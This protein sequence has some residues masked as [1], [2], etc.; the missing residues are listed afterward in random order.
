MF[1]GSFKNQKVNLIK[2]NTNTHLFPDSEYV[3]S[4]IF[5]PKRK[6]NHLRDFFLSAEEKRFKS[7][8]LKSNSVCIQGIPNKKER[9]HIEE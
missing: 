6:N 8:W 3:L 5:N 1:H 7:S 2:I 9:Q 4:P